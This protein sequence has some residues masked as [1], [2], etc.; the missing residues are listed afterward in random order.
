M[1]TYPSSEERCLLCNHLESASYHTT[2]RM[3]KREEYHKKGKEA[4]LCRPTLMNRGIDHTVVLLLLLHGSEQESKQLLSHLS[5]TSN[6]LYNDPQMQTSDS[7][8]LK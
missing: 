3:C 1:T 6:D 7:S 8:S 2:D 5:S 4:Y